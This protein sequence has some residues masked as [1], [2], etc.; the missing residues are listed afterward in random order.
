MVTQK[1]DCEETKPLSM[2]AK[3]SARNRL[4]KL[5]MFTGNQ[6]RFNRTVG[7]YVKHLVC[8]HIKHLIQKKDLKMN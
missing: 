5:S 2:K 6:N 1:V 7:L 8:S 3:R 4:L